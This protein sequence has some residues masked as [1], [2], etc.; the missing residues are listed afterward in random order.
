MAGS[1]YEIPDQRG[2]FVVVTGANSGIGYEI[3]QGLAS[4]GAEVVLAVRDTGKGETARRA[5]MAGNPAACVA[6]ASTSR[7]LRSSLRQG[8]P[9]A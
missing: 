1:R 2:R 8:S 9:R 7:A 3:A 4:A 5:I 6:V